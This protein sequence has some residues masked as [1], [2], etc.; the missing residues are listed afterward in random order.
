VISDREKRVFDYQTRI[1]TNAKG[2][3]FVLSSSEVPCQPES[4]ELLSREWSP[5]WSFWQPEEKI[6]SENVILLDIQVDR[7]GSLRALLFELP[8]SQ[9]PEYVSRLYALERPVY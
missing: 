8:N 7:R 5:V 2:H 6:S 4:R 3:G 1:V 9:L